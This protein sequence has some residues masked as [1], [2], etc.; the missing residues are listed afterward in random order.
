MAA[1]AVTAVGINPLGVARAERDKTLQGVRAFVEGVDLN[2]PMDLSHIRT[3]RYHM[4]VVRQKVLDL[5]SARDSRSREAVRQTLKEIRQMA[6]QL[7]ALAAKQES[8]GHRDDGGDVPPSERGNICLTIDGLET[9]ADFREQVK[10]LCRALDA[11][12]VAVLANEGVQEAVLMVNGRLWNLR[13][14]TEYGRPGV[15]YNVALVLAEEFRWVTKALAQRPGGAAPLADSLALWMSEASP[16]SDMDAKVREARLQDATRKTNDVHPESMR[17]LAEVRT[18]LQ[19]LDMCKEMVGAFIACGEPGFRER[20]RTLLAEVEEKTEALQAMAQEREAAGE[21]DEVAE[22][23]ASERDNVCTKL[24]EYALAEDLRAAV[25][26]VC[27]GFE[28]LRRV[29]LAGGDADAVFVEIMGSM[30][31]LKVKPGYM[32]SPIFGHV[33]TVFTEE[34]RWLV[35]FQASKEH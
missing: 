15:A 7:D 6:E 32:E 21:L 3:I 26:R 1:S 14:Q 9:D 23:P 11:V 35:S 28:R 17:S 18:G 31:D 13:H 20:I 12:R 30:T 19:S 25:V 4:D 16:N 22:R 5:G 34:Y 27:H 24:D 2:K 33:E 8:E 10:S 29:A